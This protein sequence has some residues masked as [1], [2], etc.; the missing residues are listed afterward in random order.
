MKQYRSIPKIIEN[1]DMKKYSLPEDWCYEKAKELF[2]SPDIL[3]PK[4]IEVLQGL[5]N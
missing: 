1:L 4:T 5:F 2:I 3:D